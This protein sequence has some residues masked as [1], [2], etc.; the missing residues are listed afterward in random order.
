MLFIFQGR[1]FNMS[2]LYEGQ[3]TRNKFLS[4]LNTFVIHVLSGKHEIFISS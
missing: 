3:R 4:I 1:M 2:R